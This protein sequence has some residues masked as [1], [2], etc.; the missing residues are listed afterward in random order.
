M[1]LPKFSAL[2]VL[3]GLVAGFEAP[4]YTQS[5]GGLPPSQQ[6]VYTLHA[7]TRVVLTDVTV[8]DRQGNPVHGL[9]RSAFHIFDNDK[10]QNLAS[11]EEHTG[12]RNAAPMP[13]TPSK[14]GVYSNDFLL[15]PPPVFNVLVID[16]LNMNMPDQ[17]YLNFQ[18]TH[19][20]NHLKDG[21]TLAI[22]LKWGRSLL[23]LQN[24]TSD[25]ELLLATVKKSLPRFPAPGAEYV[26]QA[27]VLRQI[28]FYLTQL[29]GRKNVLWFSSGPIS[30][31]L[32]PDPA[33]A[34]DS[35]RMRAIY[36]ELE[37][38]RI[39]VYP[40]DARGLTLTG[41]FGMNR[42][43]FFMNDIAEATGGKAFYNDNDVARIASRVM[44][45][46][47]SFYTLSYT[48]HEL[49]FDNKWHKVRVEV[50]GGSYQL[51]YRHGYFADGNNTGLREGPRTRLLEKG[52]TAEQP[53]I[54]SAP[55]IF[56]AQVLPASGMPVTP[57]KKG[58]VPYSVQYSLPL[59]S[60]N[61]LTV[62]GKQQATIG[63]AALAFD[64]NGS[65][66]VKLTQKVLA[67]FSEEKLHVSGEPTF[68]F[69]QQIDLKAGENYLYLGVWDM[70]NGHLGTI[71]LSVQAVPPKK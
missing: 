36:D 4:A 41:G 55:I 63:V 57:A 32:L 56:Q 65:A 8:S 3:C 33:T 51:G 22:Y 28:A 49:H 23:L 19:F 60:F 46:D 5:T 38:A 16:L 2:V 50:G 43:H 40:I 53:D 52:V 47:D 18:L 9:D 64:R 62:D 14:A 45:T 30:N 24:F 69:E 70:S 31:F 10:S 11:F 1:L 71:Q 35:T 13:T 20:L 37:T 58:T 21:E 66:V 68:T 12:A 6:P 61:M 17:M 48:T 15:H 29:P 59:N 44:D 27:E 67:T 39:A 26:S 54:H 34:P 7:D 25:R 42:Q